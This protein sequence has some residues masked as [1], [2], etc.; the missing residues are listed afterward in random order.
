MRKK[1]D[2]FFFIFIVKYQR[3][4]TGMEIITNIANEWESGIT[5]NIRSV[6]GEKL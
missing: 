1:I 4:I 6:G 3:E 2:N 5:E